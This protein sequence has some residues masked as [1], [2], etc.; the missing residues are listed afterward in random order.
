VSRASSTILRSI[1]R[2]TAISRSM[3]GVRRRSWS[4]SSAERTRDECTVP[5]MY[6]RRRPISPS[7]TPARVP[8]SS[9]RYMWLCTTSALTSARWAASAPTAIASSGSS[10][11]STDTPAF[12]SLRTALPA[13]SETTEIS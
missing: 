5:T 8:T 13:E 9:A 10:M 12:W 2:E 6:G 3:Y 11:T 1:I 4:R 7:A